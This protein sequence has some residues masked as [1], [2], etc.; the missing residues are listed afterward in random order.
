[1]AMSCCNGDALL[2]CCNPASIEALPIKNT[3]NC[4]LKEYPASN[5]AQK[6][7]DVA[8]FKSDSDNAARQRFIQQ[9]TAP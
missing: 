6:D 8:A 5:R 9:A 4:V 3:F 1:M 7:T 2:S